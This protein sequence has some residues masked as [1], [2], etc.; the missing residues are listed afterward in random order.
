LGAIVIRIEEVKKAMPRKSTPDKKVIT[1]V[2][3]GSPVTITLHPPTHPRRSWYAYWSGLTTSKSTGQQSLEAA[4]LTAE[5][6][7]R[8]WRAG[9]SGQRP[10]VASAALS[11]A[12]FELI[13]HAH[14]GR[15]TDPAAKARAAKSLEECLDAINAFRAITGLTPVTA[16]TPDDCAAFQRKALTMA[17][18]WRTKHPKSKETT[19]TISPNTVLK[20]SRG[21]QSAFERA[22][23]AA[24]KK[25]VRG[26]VEETKLLLSNPWN[27]FTWIEG[28][29]TAIR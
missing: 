14:F 5:N 17:K 4:I 29:Q 20:W 3:N 10:T 16:A 6:M 27:Q 7:A 11:D 15:K 8:R 22:N 13:Q 23:R 28:R 26:I 19:A 25:C 1:V 21:L 9:S 12:E 2:I 24:G 18:N